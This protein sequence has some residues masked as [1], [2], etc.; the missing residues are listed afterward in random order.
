MKDITKTLKGFSSLSEFRNFLN[1]QINDGQEISR[2]KDPQDKSKE[3]KKEEAPEA[4]SDGGD[5]AGGEEGGAEAPVVDPVA[6]P[7]SQVTVGNKKEDDMEADPEAKQVKISGKKDKIDMKP[8]AK[9]EPTN[10]I[11]SQ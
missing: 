11:N 3:Q 9:I 2:G 6:A 8:T 5:A 4:P 1:E 10:G 7:G